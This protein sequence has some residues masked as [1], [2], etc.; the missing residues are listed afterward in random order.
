[1]NNREQAITES[2]QRQRA[3]KRERTAMAELKAVADE[4]A[5]LSREIVKD[6]QKTE[7]RLQALETSIEAIKVNT[8]PKSA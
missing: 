1:M 7:A 2:L 8:K 3:A 6:Q 5:S 4:L